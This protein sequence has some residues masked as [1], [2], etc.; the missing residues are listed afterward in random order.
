MSQFLQSINAENVA[1]CKEVINKS[2]FKP[3]VVGQHL[4]I[5]LELAND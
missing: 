1:L 3:I 2:M 4:L 5:A